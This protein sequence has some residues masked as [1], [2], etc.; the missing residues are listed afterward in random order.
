MT[1]RISFLIL[2][3]ELTVILLAAPQPVQSQRTHSFDGFQLVEQAGKSRK[4]IDYRDRYQ[5][6]GTY[7]VL[8]PK[9]DQMH[10]TYASPGAAEYYRKNGKFAD[11]TVLV[12][13]V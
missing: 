3:C 12:K 10:L 7:T 9:G 8:N 11:G 5:A 4:R 2:T 1:R 6:L 13:E